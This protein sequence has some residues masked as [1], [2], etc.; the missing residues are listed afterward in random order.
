MTT[1]QDIIGKTIV[2]YR[3]GIAP[4]SGYSYNTREND[5]EC[6]VS[7]AQVGFCKEV[8]SFAVSAQVDVKYYYIGEIA[9]TGGDDEICLVN[10]RQISEDEYINLREET[11]DASNAIV[12]Y[13]ADR[14]LRL[15]YN[16][17]CIGMTEEEIEEFRNQYKK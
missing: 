12:D 4:E 3:Y 1:L 15:L 13:Y 17:F 10:V 2:G 5:R 8:Q 14:K 7:M 11:K 6:G 16:G 9:G